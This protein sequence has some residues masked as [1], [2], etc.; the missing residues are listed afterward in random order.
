MDTRKFRNIR[1]YGTTAQNVNDKVILIKRCTE[2]VEKLTPIQQAL[3]QKTK[4]FKILKVVVHKPPTIIP[5]NQTSR[6]L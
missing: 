3:K 5:Q 1:S 2:P 4:P 6:C